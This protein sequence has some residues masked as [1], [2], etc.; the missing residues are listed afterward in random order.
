MTLCVRKQTHFLT[1]MLVHKA[2]LQSEHV[3]MFETV[4]KWA[5]EAAKKKHMMQA[6]VTVH[7]GIAERRQESKFVSVWRKAKGRR[8]KSKGKCLNQE[9]GEAGEQA[10][11]EK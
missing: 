5:V 11:K 9:E 4:L 8:A 1:N 10:R 6:R 2:G 7:V 3:P